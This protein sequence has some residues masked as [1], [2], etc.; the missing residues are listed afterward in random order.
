MGEVY[1]ASHSML[2]RPTAIKMLRAEHAS[3]ERMARFEREVQLTSRLMHHNTVAIYDYGATP[4]GNFYY[5]MEFVQGVEMEELIRTDGP[6]PAARVH[7]I[8]RQACG[9]L[10]EAHGFGLIHRDIKPANMMLCPH[11]GIH[12]MVKVL[13]FG[14]V[15]DLGG[16]ADTG[17]TVAGKIVGTPLYMAPE[18]LHSA[19][20]ADGRCDLYAL[21]GVAYFL[22]C[23]EEVFL[24]E[25]VVE[26]LNQHIN[27]TPAPL[28]TRTDQPVPKGLEEL[29]MKCLAKSPDDRP[30]SAAELLVAL[31]E[32]T[33]VQRWTIA[34]AE[35]AWAAHENRKSA[36][37]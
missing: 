15:K 16:P 12:D 27:E 14:L 36:E 20:T 30:A 28:S 29:I 23:G 8:L 24:G 9:S 17:V 10:A 6:M 7:H 32:L 13:D 34:Q 11:G 35:S 26:V 31:D 1:R 2:R 4:E 21:G 33:D 18:M 25:T 22:L 5:A 3:G 19:S 37:S